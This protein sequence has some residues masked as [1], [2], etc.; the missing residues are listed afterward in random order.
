MRT[1]L[2]VHA[3][4]GLEMSRQAYIEIIG[5]IYVENCENAA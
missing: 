5:I 2:V 3:M 1:I 4:S